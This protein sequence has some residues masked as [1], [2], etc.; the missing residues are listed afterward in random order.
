M[1]F[2][3]LFNDEALDS[4]MSFLEENKSNGKDGL[5]R[6]DMSKVTDKKR[7]YVATLRFLPNFTK[8]G[9]L[10]ESAIE[11]TT[12]YVDLKDMSELRGYYDSPKNTNYDTGEPFSDTCPLSDCYWKLYNSNNAI[13]KER[14]GVLNY[15]TKWYSYVLVIEDKQQPELEGKIMVFQYGKQIR[16]KILQEDRGEITGEKCKIFSLKK[17]KDFRF[18]VKETK[19]EKNQVMPSYITSQF[20]SETSTIKIPA[21]GGEL[22]NVPLGEDGNFKDEHKKKISDFLLSRDV[23]VESFAPKAL[24]ED[25]ERKIREIISHL[26]GKPNV[27]NATEEDFSFDDVGGDTSNEKKEEVTT[28]SSSSS[29]DDDFDFDDF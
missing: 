3:D 18:I 23:E 15:S 1:S 7:G 14:A 16:E 2:D 25:Q 22:K 21:S 20:V 9:K 8:D 6:F 10:G 4:K 24:S 17:G 13:M 11:K 19:N 12:H 27:T 28:E 26:T 5:Y 29:S